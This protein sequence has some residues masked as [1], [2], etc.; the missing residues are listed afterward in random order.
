[1]SVLGLSTDEQATV[2]K[3]LQQLSDRRVRNELRRAYM[4]CKKVPVPPPTVPPYLRNIQMVLGWPAKAVEQLAR[5]VR[6]TGFSIPGADLSA[7]GLDEVLADNDYIAESR[8]AQLS[9]MEIGVSWLVT[10][11][12][13]AG[14]P[15]VLITR[16]SALDGTG[17][18]S[19]RARRLTDFL[20][21]TERDDN[22]QPRT[23]NLYTPGQVV[24][25]DRRAV[26][27]R[28][29][30][31]LDRVPV[32]PL[33]YRQRDGRPF[34]SS[35]I[36]RPLMKITDSAVRTM[37]RSEGT[38]DFYGVPLLALFGPDK[39][40]FDNNSPLKMLLS[41]MFTIPD[42]PDANTDAHERADLKQLTQASQQPH[43]D[44][45]QFWAQ[46]FAGE[47]HIPVTSLGIGMLQAN[48]TNADAYTASREDLI[49]EAE[50][51]QDGFARAH[52]RTMQHAFLLRSGETQLPAELLT[53]QPVWRD[54]R[55][56]SKS[57]MADWLTKVASVIPWIAETDTVLDLVG[58]P[59]ET[60]NQLRGEHKAAQNRQTLNMLL[61]QAAPSGVTS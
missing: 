49:S 13:G 35:R 53:L 7:F 38:A 25:V 19:V 16:Q 11:R 45:L 4:D 1:M 36:T 22:G 34:G 21:V 20:S 54:P 18:W 2:N 55:H 61:T 10:T 43:V 6:L 52:L 27:A 14:E 17:T 50:D 57:A 42:N 59:E 41:S 33:V 30:T 26:V 32:E 12:G 48:P 8:M 28:V 40:F 58:L 24:M 51:A 47:A 31:G 46:L 37:L 5:R 15:D 29:A 39:S 23:Y 9:A 60:A 3:L 44:Q 56:E